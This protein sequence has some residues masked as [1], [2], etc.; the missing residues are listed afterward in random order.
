MAY[1][2]IRYSKSNIM[3]NPGERNARVGLNV[4]SLA[5]VACAPA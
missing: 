3:V 1:L 2:G 4:L 5:A